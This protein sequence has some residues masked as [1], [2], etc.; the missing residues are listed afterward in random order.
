MKGRP[1]YN[2]LVSLNQ[3]CNGTLALHVKATAD[4]S[5]LERCWLRNCA[6]TVDIRIHTVLDKR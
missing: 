3:S 2:R 6:G 1:R 4:L 5:R